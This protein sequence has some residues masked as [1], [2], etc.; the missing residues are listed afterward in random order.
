M[1][2][3]AAQLAP[4][5]HHQQLGNIW[6]TVHQANDIMATGAAAE[7]NDLSVCR[8]RHGLT[9]PRG[10]VRS[11]KHAGTRPEAQQQVA[12]LGEG[13]CRAQILL[14]ERICCHVSFQRDR[15]LATSVCARPLSRRW[16]AWG[17]QEPSQ[18][19]RVPHLLLPHC[20]HLPSD[21]HLTG[22]LQPACH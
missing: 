18:P 8:S 19:I 4:C 2:G 5:L 10:Q 7:T 15:A 22:A 13:A 21:R 3:P 12:H 16:P 6:R 20:R 17:T 1:F 9:A 11:A 14:V